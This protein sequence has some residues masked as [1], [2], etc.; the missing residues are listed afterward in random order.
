MPDK[1]SPNH[2]PGP[3]VVL[4]EPEI[5]SLLDPA[6]CIAAVEQAFTAYATGGAELP[7]V[8][9]LDVPEHRGEI[10]IKAGHLRGGNWYACK[11]ASGFAGRNDGVV[12]TF[13]ARTGAP[14]GILFDGGYLTDLRTAAA[15]AVAA[16][17][18][19]P[20]TVETI[21]ILGTGIQSRLQPALLSSVRPFRTV[22][23]WGRR[24]EAA[25]AT[26]KE[27]GAIVSDTVE[28]AVDG[29]QIV[30]T[31]TA[32]RTPILRAEWLAPGALVIAVGSDGPDKQELDVGVL[33]RADRVVADSLPQCARLGEI[34]HALD[35]GVLTTD[36]VT[37][38]GQITSGR[39]PGRRT[40]TETI[41]CD[42][43][44]VG[45]Q[46]VAAAT[47]VMERAL[48]TRDLYERRI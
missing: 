31:V 7:G 40:P 32:S 37:E 14:A 4:R 22:R 5:R 8:I 48:A 24:R 2:M 3:I 18:L 23:V 25:E 29:A 20:A 10:H 19:A 9:H 43:T 41:V 42:L 1:R 47:V 30:I 15:G 6:S 35:A 11:F 27:I 21:A 36:A 46:D 28:A 26:A 45:V 38:L 33:A 12:L 13:D 44:G 39:A 34:H 17:H 16:R